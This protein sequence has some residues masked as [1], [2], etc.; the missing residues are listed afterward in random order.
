MRTLRSRDAL[1]DTPVCVGFEA[2]DATYP[3]SRFILTVREREAW[4][5]SCE[6]Y[7]R[8]LE[9]FLH[10]QPNDPYAV[11][12][13]S[14]ST[15][16]YGTPAFERDAFSRAYDAYHNRVARHFRDR[17]RDVLRLDLFSGEGWP[18]LCE[19]LGRPTPAGPFPFENR[20]ADHR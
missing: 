14:I 4:L 8:R 5:D 11:Y 17:E 7:W 9:S 13:M 15:H 3:R 12:M 19:F 16:L 6:A 1:T 20:A 10:G 18:E 2:L